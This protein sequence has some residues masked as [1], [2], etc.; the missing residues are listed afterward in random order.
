MLA[1]KW[2]VL[3]TTITTKLETTENIVL[4]CV[5]L[6]NAVITLEGISDSLDEIEF[7]DDSQAR[8]GNGAAE[9][10]HRGRL[11]QYPVWI[12]QKLLE[13]VNGHGALPWQ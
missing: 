6:H 5:A 7:L 9:H 10:S 12:R 13:F 8:Q 1:A 3:H 11:A 2:R 4:A